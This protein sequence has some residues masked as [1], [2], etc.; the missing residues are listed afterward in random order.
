M[1]ASAWQPGDPPGR[2]RFVDLFD[3]LPLVLELGGRL[4]PVTVAYETWGHRAAD[5]SNAVLVE[6]ALTG[7][8]HVAGDVEP[9]HPAPGWWEGVIG[10]GRAIDTDRWWVVCA[11]VLGGCQ[12]TTGPS[13]T[14]P[15]GR[16]WGPRFPVIT[17]RDQVAVEETLANLLGVQRWA[18]VVG[19]SMGGQAVLHWAAKHPQMVRG[20]VALATGSGTADRT[21]RIYRHRGYDRSRWTG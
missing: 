18:A 21:N 6:H 17:I 4:G 10:P 16:P 9:G 3:D 20:A 19:G 2:R 14:A 7:D 15:D 11:N 5:G 12:G 8:S 13:S 1:T